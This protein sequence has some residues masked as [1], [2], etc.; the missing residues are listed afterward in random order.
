M[1]SLFRISHAVG[2]LGFI[3][4]VMECKHRLWLIYEPFAGCSTISECLNRAKTMDE[5][6]LL[7]TMTAAILFLLSCMGVVSLLYWF[8]K[9][10][11][12]TL[13]TVRSKGRFSTGV[14]SNISSSPSA[15]EQ[16]PRGAS[17]RA[18]S[19]ATAARRVYKPDSLNQKQE[20][21][22]PKEI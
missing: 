13:L 16:Y 19:G 3:G 20:L 8:V 2:G 22:V 7:G 5:T 10:V 1:V 17:R 12:S 14:G 11:R 18:Q 4:L 15:G 9:S 6:T 21:S